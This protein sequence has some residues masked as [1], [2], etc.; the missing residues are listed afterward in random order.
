MQRAHETLKHKRERR[1]QIKKKREVGEEEEEQVVLLHKKMPTVWL[2]LKKSLHCKSEPS[3]VHDPK[4]RL[5]LGTIFTRKAGRSGCSRSIANLRDVIN[6]SKRHLEK[7]PSCSP[8]SIGSSELL[9]PIT[10][11]VILNNS[12]C[13]L[14]ISTAELDYS[15]IRTPR[16]GAQGL[17]HHTLPL[18][19]SFRGAIDTTPPK[20]CASF[21]SER[22]GL[23]LGFAAPPPRLSH[24]IHLHKS[25]AAL[26]CLKCGEKF[27][28]WEILEAHHLSV[29]AGIII[30]SIMFGN[31]F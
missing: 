19:P 16:I 1:V 18:T 26:T 4:S 20:K 30:P 22:E 3:E 14:R 8:R 31:S 6:G 12:R 5:N 11:E 7:P 17:G 23:R 24:E 27:V 2:S 9:N 15:Y 25:T 10:H 13:E 29:H 28:K 21:S